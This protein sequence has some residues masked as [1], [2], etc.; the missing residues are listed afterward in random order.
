MIITT[1]MDVY[2]QLKNKMIHK[3]CECECECFDDGKAKT[4]GIIAIIIFVLIIAF[5]I[6]TLIALIRYRK[7]MPTGAIV[8]ATL[9]LLFIVFNP[10]I[11][12]IL[13][14]YFVSLANN[15]IIN[16]DKL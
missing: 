2:V 13:I 7:K 6:G 1:P 11:S 14:I 3:Q 4:A 9:G 8:M 16:V 5:Y 10:V 12:L 15:G